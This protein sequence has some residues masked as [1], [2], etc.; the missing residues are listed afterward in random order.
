MQEFYVNFN[1]DLDTSGIVHMHQT[2][3]RE[4]WILLSLEVTEAHYGLTR[5]NIIHVLMDS[6]LSITV[7]MLYGRDDAW[8]L[9]ENEFEYRHLV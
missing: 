7:W 1:I 4:K 6:N 9:L 2:W 3:V 8:P 5:D